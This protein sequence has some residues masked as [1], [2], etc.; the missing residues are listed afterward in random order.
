MCLLTSFICDVNDSLILSVYKECNFFIQD[1][2]QLR[3]INEE[4]HTY[5]EQQH[6]SI[7]QLNNELQLKQQTISE[8]EEKNVSIQYQYSKILEKA[9][10][11]M[12]EA[13]VKDI[14]SECR[15]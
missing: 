8:L 14:K 7:R 9:N 3:S 11:T 12:G 1:I 13:K 6:K 10:E 4:N 15:L 5:I 2:A